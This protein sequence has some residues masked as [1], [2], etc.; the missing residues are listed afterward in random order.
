M[1]TGGI[2][3]KK[4]NCSAIQNSNIKTLKHRSIGLL[5]HRQYSLLGFEESLKAGLSD[6]AVS[7]DPLMMSNIFFGSTIVF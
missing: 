6:I 3:F 5:G 7:L 2:C 4:I 1:I